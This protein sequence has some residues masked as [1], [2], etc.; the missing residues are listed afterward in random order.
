MVQKRDLLAELRGG[1]RLTTR[2][3]LYLILR[4]SLPAIVA[5]VTSVVMQYIDASMVGQLG[6]QNSAAIGLISTTTWLIGGLCGAVT[7]GFTVQVAQRIGAGED[8]TAR[9]IMRHGLL[10]AFCFACLLC[11]LCLS[12][13][14]WL[15]RFLGGEDAILERSTSYFRIYACGL[16]AM[17]MSGIAGGM[18]QSSGN[19]K[20]PST[21]NILQCCLN[22]FFNALFIFESGERTLM[23]ITFSMPGF[24]LGVKG[25][26]LGTAASQAICALLMLFFLLF[27][28]ET[29]KLR[30]QERCPVT[31]KEMRMFF[32]ISIPVG[33]ENAIMGF[34]QV[35]STKI[36]SPLGSV[37]LA[38]NSFSITAESLCYMPGFGIS[39]AAVTLVGQSIGA[40]RRDLTKR[41]GYMTTCMGIAVMAVIGVLMY[42]LAPQMIGLLS[43]DPEIQALGAKVLR[44][45]AFAEPMF[46]ASIVAS[47]VF[48]GAGDTLV[49]SL[50]NLFSMWAVRL[51][52]AAL[53]APRIGLQGVWLAMC[54]ELCVRGVLY[55][56]MLARKKF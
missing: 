44:I 23:G 36:V 42:L 6:A 21:V 30:R 16:I 48:R 56:I 33:T 38:A 5:Q 28:S 19:M 2:D 53:L 39:A 50:I 40:G 45:E 10:T 4:L 29:L 37:A 51:T 1:A 9:G 20:V 26:A 55:L 13:S 7:T 17:Q 46:A 49:P 14:S 52:L 32:K 25:A 11:T 41:L 27:R 54:I 35:M 12:I 43:P 22:V 34:A 15:P 47:G 31:K 8:K 18:L 3:Q 24:G